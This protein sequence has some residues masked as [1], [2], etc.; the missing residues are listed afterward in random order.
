MRRYFMRDGHIAAVE[1]LTELSD[2]EA[3]AKA[4]ALFSE[5]KHLFE[6]FELWG[7]TRVLVRHPE[8]AAPHNAAVWPLYN[9]GLFP[10]SSMRMPHADDKLTLADTRDLAD[11]V[12]FALRFFEGRKRKHDADAFV[13]TIAAERVV[14]HLERAGFVLM[15]KPPLDGHS[16]LGRV[17]EGSAPLDT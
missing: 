12:A 10:R 13:A 2:E 16:A 1:E 17:F 5:R 8:P 3:T 9:A 4:H 15:T 11:A 6:G 7:R 14:R